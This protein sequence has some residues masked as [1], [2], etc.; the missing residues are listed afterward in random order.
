MA[1]KDNTIGIYNTTVP[2]VMAF[3]A[4]HEAKQYMK[5]GKPKGSPKYS[6]SFMYAPAHA[7]LPEMKKAAAAA[8][9]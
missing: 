3:P 2:A 5:D 7:D 6:A 8:V 4:L 9:K 1:T